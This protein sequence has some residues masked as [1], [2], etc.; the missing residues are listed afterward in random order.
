VAS[1]LCH[2]SAATMVAYLFSFT[3]GFSQVSPNAKLNQG[4]V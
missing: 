4:T 3:P 1:A 2:N